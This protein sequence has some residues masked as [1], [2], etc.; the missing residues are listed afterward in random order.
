M[1]RKEDLVTL[2][3]VI[4]LFLKNWY[5]FV[6]SAV[7]CTALGWGY[8]STLSP[9]YQRAA[10]MLVKGDNSSSSNDLS[11]MLELNG[12]PGGSRV[13]NE[14]YILRSY[15]IVNEVVRR[16]H[17]DVNYTVNEGLRH[18]NIFGEQPFEIRFLDVY[19]GYTE[20]EA[21]VI[22][23]KVCELSNWE[24]NGANVDFSVK[25]IFNDT[26]Y[27]PAGRIIVLPDAVGSR[28]N[29]VGKIIKVSRSDL[30]TATNGVLARI[31]TSALEQKST[32]VK[33]V[34]QDTNIPRAD[35]ILSMILQVYNETIVE[36]KNRMASNTARFI[37][38]RI[39]IIS[40][41]LGEVEN[42]LTEFKQQNRIVDINAN[43]TMY[44]Q[45]GSR[46][47]EESIQL[48][49]QLSVV[50]FVKNY[51]TDKT[52]RNELIPNVTGVGDAGVQ[53]QI[54]AYNEMMLRRNRL[55]SNSGENNPVVENMNKNLTAMRSTIAG[56]IDNYVRTIRLRLKNARDVEKN[57]NRNIENVPQQEKYALDVMRQQ[58]IKETLYT[59]LL[60]KREETA[61]QLAITE[62]NIR[63]VERPYGSR[64]PIS[65]NNKLILLAAVGLGLAI[66]FFIF[67]LKS[68]LNTGV[69]GRKDIEDATTLPVIGEIPSKKKEGNEKDGRIVVSEKMNDRITE[70]FRMMRAN[71]D[72]MSRG[73]KVLM[74][75]STMAGEGKTFI[76]RNYAVVLASTGKKVI[77]VDTDIRKRT[78]SKISGV[79]R[80][81]GVSTF[82]S[83]ASDELLPLIVPNQLPGVDM[84]LAGALPPNPAELLMSERLE[85]L[86]D[87]LKKHYDYIILDNVPALVIADA[88]IVNRVADVTLYVMREGAIDR[89]YLPELERLYQEGK[90]KKMCIVL[91]DVSDKTGKYGYGYGYGYSYGYDYYSEDEKRKQKV[92]SRKS[93]F[94]KLFF[95]HKK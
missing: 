88:A 22:G 1:P 45:E 79:K 52:K 54:E 10:V 25:A 14:I 6:L 71:L 91:N 7:V 76:S 80:S 81:E 16:L 39:V 24:I 93:L 55:V 11:A 33:I 44:L 9:V 65:P 78:Q 21:R 4:E 3:D 86:I 48:E 60:Q 90:F 5:W 27:T 37:D 32:L 53:S 50:E 57:V 35:A 17:L 40:H 77:L 64:M 47:K 89:R 49:A 85:L 28:T 26:I 63:V 2:R 15:Q 94:R 29:D 51:V 61:M 59:Y 83:G 67:Y 38:E 36:D 72:F 18:R 34:C 74:F 66:P 56:S 42:K 68:L 84:L 58:S 8:L 19:P 41:E 13:E 46:A 95:T 62:A 69:R 75:T 82:L 70:A 30:E 43:A 87:I 31:Q 92:Y 23:G 12:I 73:A 20:F